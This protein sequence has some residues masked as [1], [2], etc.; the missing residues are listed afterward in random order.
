M[1][2]SNT[3]IQFD[4]IFT[5]IDLKS[6]YAM[7]T[8]NSRLVQYDKASGTITAQFFNEALKTGTSLTVD[9]KNKTAY[10]VTSSGLVSVAIQ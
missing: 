2:N 9:E 4:K 5:T 8:Q 3:P 7:D 10:V 1:E 6:L